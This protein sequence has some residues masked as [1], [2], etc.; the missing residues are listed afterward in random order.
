[1]N[2]ALPDPTRRL[3]ITAGAISA[4][5]A[6]P[7]SASLWRPWS[8]PLHK[9]L[10]LAPLA[11]LAACTSGPDFERPALP[12][13]AAGYAPA[14]MRGV[15]MGEGPAEHWWTA[16]GSAELDRLVESA[17]S[18]NQT[19]A[20]S[21]A[22]LAR[23]RE[24]V[25]AVRGKALPQIDATGRA[26]YQQVNLSAIG[27]SERAGAA[28]IGNPEFD[29]YTIG[30]GVTYD[31]D[32]FGRNRRAL[33]QAAAKAEAQQRATEAAHLLI[34]GRVVTQAL[35]IAALNDRIVTERA[36]L[37]EDERNVSLT[38]TRRRAGAGTL[39]EVLSAQGQLASDRATLPLLEQQLAEARATL[40]V[41]LGVSPA[42]L[43][44]TGFALSS[45][46]LP[47]TVPVALPSSMV[48]K[49]PDILEAE[50]R[51]HAATAA[52]GVATAELYPNITLGASITQS[53][54]DADSILSSR[55]TGF[56]IFAG[57]TAPI[58]R[59]G[60]LKANQ[61]GAQADARA[62]AANYRQ[63]VLE[64]FAQVSSLI[65]AMDSD[66]RA[67]AAQRASADVAQR[68]L[69]LSR[70]SFEVGNSGVLQVL[71][72]NRLYQRAQLDLLDARM[73]QYLNVARLHVATAGGWIDPAS[74]I[75]E[76]TAIR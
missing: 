67:L 10:Y 75:P 13:A 33:E 21:R 14:P 52:V 36:L 32:L 68:S 66:G 11:L 55:F 72:A 23:A 15:A 57:L 35:T 54:S 20:A 25:R 34:A 73:R 2:P 39:V 49:R 7:K 30:G 19:L 62:A 18:R 43:E 38:E 63:A 31:L 48:R 61:R 9:F 16:F 58:F 28:G 37:A 4:E 12:S 29:L 64:A 44:P 45:F 42:E 41:L 56:D 22:T 74:D 65:S 24:H 17:L 70:R 1:M 8:D 71:D 53:S 27:L 47:A 40:A 69:H 76:P 3:L 60:T 5:M 51:F 50:A 26:E 6:L 59:G 46:T